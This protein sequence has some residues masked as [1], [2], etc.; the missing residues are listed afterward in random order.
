MDQMK[1]PHKYGHFVFGVLQSGVT[2]AV[3]SAIA[4]Y[5]TNSG[6]HPIIDWLSTWGL[7]WIMMLPVVFLFAPIL[8]KAVEKITTQSNT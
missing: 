4:V 2:C 5:K 7:S 1:I 3:A 6:E 8:R